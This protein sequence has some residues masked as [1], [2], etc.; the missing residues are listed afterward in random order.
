MQVERYVT[1]PDQPEPVGATAVLE[2]PVPGREP[3]IPGRSGEPGQLLR[4]HAVQEWMRG[5][6]RRR[7]LDHGTSPPSYSSRSGPAFRSGWRAARALSHSATGTMGH[8]G[9]SPKAGQP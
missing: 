2:E 5:Q 9:I 8:G 7:D 6:S 1:G 4:G 3:H